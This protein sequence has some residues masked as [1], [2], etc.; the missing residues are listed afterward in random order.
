[1][2]APGVQTGR[3]TLSIPA[4]LGLR[5]HD[6]QPVTLEDAAHMVRVLTEGNTARSKALRSLEAQGRQCDPVEYAALSRE[7]RLDALRVRVWSALEALAREAA[8]L[9]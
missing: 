9:L 1:M 5:H 7:A 3:D 4:P 2:K 8:V 6:A